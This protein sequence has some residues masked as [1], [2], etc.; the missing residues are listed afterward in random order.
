MEKIMLK[1]EN[2]IFKNLYN[3]FGWEI[4]NAFQLKHHS[5]KAPKQYVESMGTNWVQKNQ[6]T[7]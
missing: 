4:E 6:V 7:L 2:K 5:Y 1:S 3:E